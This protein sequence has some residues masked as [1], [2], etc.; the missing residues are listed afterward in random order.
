LDESLPKRSFPFNVLTLAG[1]TAF[2]QAIGMLVIPLLT[3]LYSP[4]DY[5]SYALYTA[6][7][8][9]LS[10][11]VHFRYAA[12]IMLPKEDEEALD[13]L[14]LS[15]RLSIFFGLTL[16][17][18]FFFSDPSFMQLP[19]VTD[20]HW[21]VASICLA[22]IFTGAI[23]SYS[24][25]TNR[26]KNYFLMSLSRV[27]QVGGMVISQSAAGFILGTTL[28][29]L[30]YGHIIGQVIGLAAMI[31][32]N[33]SLKNKPLL[34]SPVA[35]LINSMTRYKRFPL[36]TSWGTMLEGVSSYGTPLL[37]AMY[38]Q[39]DMVGKYALAM[40]ALSAPVMLIGHSV[41]QV[42]YQRMAENEKKGL[43]IKDLVR[44]VLIRQFFISLVI[45]MII[46]FFGP[47]LF[48]F[49]FGDA[50]SAAGQFA[51]ILVPIMFV[52]FITAA[53]STVLLVKERQDL[54]LY[55]Q[56]LRAFITVASIVIPG[57]AGFNEIELLNVFS[58]SRAMANLVYLAIICKVARLF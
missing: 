40:T 26:M 50:W 23:L 17:I 21:V 9:F 55:V 22:L 36:F 32:G 13:V 8:N 6:V 45:G 44:S 28:L 54:L 37:L 48:A 14:R 39:S 12:A 49:F 31:I 51:K 46:Y 42:L 56:I 19:G 47:T 15:L 25:W 20:N 10:P 33:K 57:M 29:G 7:F 53:L 1:G 38:F 5:G 43:D 41:S 16:F 30:V 3:R 52:Q 2:S 4:S 24:V 58:I 34:F 11:I 27:T 18:I 35:P